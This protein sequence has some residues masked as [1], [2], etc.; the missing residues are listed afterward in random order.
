MAEIRYPQSDLDRLS[1]LKQCD[2]ETA[3]DKAAS[4]SYL[5]ANLETGLTEFITRFAPA[6]TLVQEKRGQRGVEVD[7][8]QTAVAELVQYIRDYW[9][10]LE[11]RIV[12]ENLPRGLFI[13]YN[14]LRSGSNPMGTSLTKL[15]QYGD[16]IIAGEARIVAKGYAPMCNPNVLEIQ[17]KRDAA[18]TE[19]DDVDGAN[20]ELDRAQHALDPLRAE[21]D[22]LIRVINAQ[23]DASLYGMSADDVRSIKVRYGY[24]FYDRETATSTPLSAGVD[25]EPVDPIA[26]E[27]TP[28]V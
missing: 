28:P 17:A 22:R 5:V 9:A 3:R 6:V 20:S 8:K 11:R 21:A 23:M 13:E 25:P 18:F 4:A 7:E 1:L 12:R 27:E 26:P 16:A 14:L 19:A 15:L 24:D 2:K 10:G